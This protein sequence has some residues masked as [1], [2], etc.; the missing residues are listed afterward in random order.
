[1]AQL[2]SRREQLRLWQEQK[3]TG[4][5]SPTAQLPTGAT[6]SSHQNIKSNSKHTSGFGTA[7]APDTHKPPGASSSSS[8]HARSGSSAGPATFSSSPRRHAQ[9]NKENEPGRPSLCG[10]RRRPPQPNAATL[11]AGAQVYKPGFT[12]EA[13]REHGYVS[14]VPN[15]L[16]N[17]AVDVVVDEEMPDAHDPQPSVSLPAHP[18]SSSKLLFGSAGTGLQS[19][20]TVPATSSSS[21]APPKYNDG[22][23]HV[24]LHADAP[25]GPQNLWG[26][27]ARRLPPK[28]KPAGTQSHGALPQSGG[29]HRKMN[30]KP[31]Y[32]SAG[33]TPQSHKDP[34]AFF[35]SGSSLY[36][37]SSSGHHHLP[38]GPASTASRSRAGAA[39]SVSS[40]PVS[41]KV[42]VLAPSNLL[43][44]SMSSD[45]GGSSVPRARTPS[46]S[47]SVTARGG[48]QAGTKASESRRT[49]PPASSRTLTR[50]QSLHESM[51]VESG[52]VRKSSSAGR[53]G[54]G[55][56]RNPPSSS[57]QTR[58]PSPNAGANQIRS[59]SLQTVESAARAAGAATSSTTS[60]VEP[61]PM[62][63]VLQPAKNRNPS[64]ERLLPEDEVA[65]APPAAA[66]PVAAPAA[67]NNVGDQ[68]QSRPQ[69]A[70][71]QDHDLA[72]PAATSS[73]KLTKSSLRQL[74]SP[75]KPPPSPGEKDEDRLP[76]FGVPSPGIGLPLHTSPAHPDSSSPPEPNLYGTYSDPRRARDSVASVATFGGGSSNKKNV[77]AGVVAAPEGNH[78]ALPRAREARGENVSPGAAVAVQPDSGDNNIE[79]SGER[80]LKEVDVL[81]KE[82]QEQQ[83]EFDAS[84]G[85]LPD[86]GTSTGIVTDHHAE[87]GESSFSIRMDSN[88]LFG[89]EN[90]LAKKQ[91]EPKSSE[92]SP[93]IIAP[94]PSLRKDFSS[95]QEQLGIA[96]EA[97]N[98]QLHDNN[99]LEL[100]DFNPELVSDAESE[101]VAVDESS[102]DGCVFRIPQDCVCSRS[103]F[104]QTTAELRCA[105]P[106]GTPV[107]EF[108]RKLR[109][110]NWT[111]TL[112]YTV[113]EELQ[114]LPPASARASLV[115][116]GGPS[117]PPELG[118]PDVSS[119]RS[120]GRHSAK[121][122]FGTSGG[123]S[124]SSSAPPVR[125]PQHASPAAGKTP[126]QRKYSSHVSSAERQK[127][128]TVEL[129]NPPSSEPP[130]KPTKTHVSTPWQKPDVAGI[131]P[132]TE[133]SSVSQLQ[134]NQTPTS[135]QRKNYPKWFK[136]TPSGQ[137]PR[138]TTPVSARGRGGRPSDESGV[139]AFGSEKQEKNNSASFS[140][141]REM[142]EDD[143]MTGVMTAQQ[144]HASRSVDQSKAALF[145]VQG[146]GASSS[147]S[148]LFSTSATS[149]SSN[150]GPQAQ[151]EQ[152]AAAAGC[153][154]SFRQ[155][156]TPPKRT[157]AEDEKEMMLMENLQQRV[158]D[159][160]RRMQEK[161]AESSSQQQEKDRDS[162]V[163]AEQQPS[164]AAARARSRSA[165]FEAARRR[166]ENAKEEGEQV[167]R[168][169][170]RGELRAPSG[171]LVDRTGKINDP[172]V[173][174]ISLQNKSPP[175][176]P[177]ADA[178]APAAVA[179]QNAESRVSR[180][181]AAKERARALFER[182]RSNAS[183]GTAL[184]STASSKLSSVAGGSEQTGTTLQE[185]A[186]TVISGTGS[187]S[188]SSSQTNR[189]PA[190]TSIFGANRS[191]SDT[192]N[193]KKDR[194]TSGSGLFGQ[195][196]DKNLQQGGSS[197][198]ASSSSSS[199]AHGARSKSD[200]STWNSKIQDTRS[201]VAQAK[202]RLSSTTAAD[203]NRGR[204]DQNNAPAFLHSHSSAEES[205]K[206]DNGS[207]ISQQDFSK[208]EVTPARK[209]KHEE[210]TDPLAL[211][212][213]TKAILRD[214]KHRPKIL[215]T[216]F[217][218]EFEDHFSPELPEDEP[219]PDG[220][221]LLHAA[222]TR[223]GSTDFRTDDA[224]ASAG[225]SPLD[226]GADDS[227]IGPVQSAAMK[228]P[229]PLKIDVQNDLTGLLFR[230]TPTELNGPQV[231][232]QMNSGGSSQPQEA[233]EP[234]WNQKTT[235]FDDLNRVHFGEEK[236]EEDGAMDVSGSEKKEIETSTQQNQQHQ[237]SY[238]DL[239]GATLFEQENN[240]SVNISGD[241]RQN[242]SQ[243]GRYNKNKTPRADRSGLM[244]KTPHSEEQSHHTPRRDHLQAGPLLD[245][246]EDVFGDQNRREL[247]QITGDEDAR[248]AMMA[249]M[250]GSSSMSMSSVHKS[251]PKNKNSSSQ[252]SGGDQPQV[253][254]FLPPKQP[255]SGMSRLPL[256][257]G[258]VTSA[259]PFLSHAAAS[260]SRL[261]IGIAAISPHRGSLEGSELYSARSPRG[262]VPG[263][264]ISPF[265]NRD[266]RLSAGAMGQNFKKFSSPAPRTPVGFSSK[267]PFVKAED[268]MPQA[269]R[270][271]SPCGRYDFLSE[272]K[273][274]A[275]SGRGRARGNPSP[276]Q[277]MGNRRSNNTSIS[278]I[279]MKPISP[280]ANISPRQPASSSG[281]Q[282]LSGGKP[283]L[284]QQE[285]KASAGLSPLSNWSGSPDLK[286]DTFVEEFRQEVM[287]HPGHPIDDAWILQEKTVDAEQI[288]CQCADIEHFYFFDRR[289]IISKLI[290]FVPCHLETIPEE[291]EDEEM[292]Y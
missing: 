22:N 158:A 187:S 64:E 213:D 292:M 144:N 135:D 143:P 110:P 81:E 16:H 195:T 30:S 118:L 246:D 138:S 49:I 73:L 85:L 111:E 250:S 174:M 218:P 55:A 261:G 142:K 36:G 45:R 173:S 216:V 42:A 105:A 205:S 276:L 90:A 289:D 224:F 164:G 189:G 48:F 97:E 28:N 21:S 25:A 145:V 17:S 50:K 192:T 34:P 285:S 14:S 182:T 236:E 190:S 44:T 235:V 156:K 176:K 185:N 180:A 56:T 267:S 24:H 193:N 197:S 40:R 243:Q 194:A 247:H 234:R 207:S 99:S 65:P 199:S 231:L 43:S 59:K 167:D 79:S 288:L 237:K 169:G 13:L 84:R 146:G 52:Q 31:T 242:L 139:G 147:S 112:L 68:E 120:A 179:E 162:R 255:T 287:D 186:R 148:A 262:K 233:E 229:S 101:P 270:S 256:A 10:A 103:A 202:M 184:V 151:L 108:R 98:N 1:M 124:S 272:E 230:K 109:K 15:S 155:S 122:D 131:S 150:A 86:N 286:H 9:H 200:H 134:K 153:S 140:A 39:M 181:F 239:P 215:D 18:S 4:K 70:S 92:S 257:P 107:P 104:A 277:A 198:S 166:F 258:A 281:N 5:A 251:S 226:A 123:G 191:S 137:T 223:L 128:A 67:N 29:E 209:A 129:K 177:P 269:R 219:P 87:P 290:D 188:A 168:I 249:P 132:A 208:R 2:L 96:G 274:P 76:C 114:N 38:T 172:D 227:G 275:R 268:V 115:E 228:S 165:S 284:Q 119:A 91:H 271:G 248:G 210:K 116:L 183:K 278:P 113:A 217:T 57:R 35:N 20:G 63:I 141:E 3:R 66:P 279:R 282:L 203:A 211:S 69:E 130:Q 259:A 7:R 60:R 238:Q 283:W 222:T 232:E 136:R 170:R 154:S 206:K 252:G 94:G 75:R 253:G 273:S 26:S 175:E 61:Q 260:S 121:K 220:Q 133:D 41:G 89:E 204:E 244:Y 37:Q 93:E 74:S 77:V 127:Q 159:R 266:G 245:E 161:K 171:G 240:N 19:G 106:R 126:L 280:S 54:G 46:R 58:H 71:A 254:S 263:K 32:A 157:A 62:E 152:A 82:H 201:L 72:P 11:A 95:E 264:F 241:Y 33:T 83:A 163:A 160:S 100:R 149:S 291:D 80:I 47:N 125:G 51:S 178:T 12:R 8:G 117:P 88:I 27:A 265:G 196:A 6:T 212:Q 225:P 23:K 102:S 221:L 53:I 214:M 78:A